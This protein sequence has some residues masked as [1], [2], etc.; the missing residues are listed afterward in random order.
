MRQASKR[1][2]L[3]AVVIVWAVVGAVPGARAADGDA[4]SI[5]DATNGALVVPTTVPDLALPIV[6]RS[7]VNKE[8][9]AVRI[10]VTP[11]REPGTARTVPVTVLDGDRSIDSAEAWAVNG[12]ASKTFVLKA[13][14]VASGAFTGSI[15]LIYDDKDHPTTL[16]IAREHPAPSVTVDAV[17]ASTSNSAK[18]TI[19]ENAGKVAVLD[20]PTLLPLVNVV[21]TDVSVLGKYKNTK[22]EQLDTTT[23]T[24]KPVTTGITLQPLTTAELRVTVEN[25]RAPGKYE[26]T[27]RVANTGENASVE[28]KLTFLIR[29]WFVWAVL[30]LALGLGV[31]EWLRQRLVTDANL[32]ERVKI[33]D[34]SQDLVAIR[35]DISQDD[36][37]GVKDALDALATAI[38]HAAALGNAGA[39]AAELKPLREKLVERVER[40]TTW[41]TVLKNESNASQADA[42]TVA[43]DLAAA[44]NFIQLGVGAA[45]DIDTKLA[46]AAAKTAGPPPAAD[47]VTAATPTNPPPNQPSAGELRKRLEFRHRLTLGVG[48]AI[49]AALAMLLLYLPNHTWGSPTDVLTM[50]LWALGVHQITG[51]TASA[52]AKS[53]LD[54]V[55]A[56]GA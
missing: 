51:V 15:H 11:L 40:V 28:T 55:V 27:L 53:M 22:I 14:L 36:T 17:P 21:S 56:A 2:F 13:T 33:A 12:L 7:Q 29:R 37:G 34:A 30:I 20:R 31:G 48:M 46:D 42:S 32:D 8:T 38:A 35:A 10:E 16:T 39:T 9:A 41:V 3:L 43:G 50:F 19:R 49:V 45:S 23:N 44:R 52:S 5:D 47:G 18:V 54:K 25:L 4:L 26:G 6:V 1:I 24:Y